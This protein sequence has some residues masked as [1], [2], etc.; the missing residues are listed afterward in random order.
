METSNGR[1]MW[2]HISCCVAKIMAVAALEIILWFAILRIGQQF[3][4]K[5]YTEGKYAIHKQVYE[6]WW[7]SSL[8]HKCRSQLVYIPHYGIK[9]SCLLPHFFLFSRRSLLCSPDRLQTYDPLLLALSMRIITVC[10]PSSGISV[11]NFDSKKSERV[12]HNTM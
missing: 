7:T 5:R 2:V 8:T 12:T 9:N 10:Y 3:C 6:K 4:S 1:M 11:I